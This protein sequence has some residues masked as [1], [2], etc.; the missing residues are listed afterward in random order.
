MKE[1]FKNW[2]PDLMNIVLTLIVGGSTD[3]GGLFIFFVVLNIITI[4][5][6]YN[7]LKDK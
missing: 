6:T 2:T 1:W 7:K 3:F 5:M 4:I